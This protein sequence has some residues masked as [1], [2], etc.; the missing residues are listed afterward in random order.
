MNAVEAIGIAEGYI[1][2]DSE[3]KYIEAWQ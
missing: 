1:E 3:E 2:T